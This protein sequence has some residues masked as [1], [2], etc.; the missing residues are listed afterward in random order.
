MG[1][2]TKSSFWTVMSQGLIFFIGL[3][4]SIIVARMLNPEGKGIYVLAVL[5]PALLPYFAHFGIGLAAVFYLGNGKYSPKL[6]LGNNVILAFLHSVFAILIGLMVIYFAGKRLF[7]GVDKR[8]LLI[9]L[10][11][12][13]SQLC[14]GLVL[15]ILLGL[16]KIALYN[17]IQILRAI[18]LFGLVLFFLVG[19]DSGVMGAI[20]TEIIA[21]L[22]VCFAT[23]F[24]VLRHTNGILLKLDRHYLKDAYSYGIILYFSYIFSILSTRLNLLLINMYLNPYMVGLFT[25]G[26]GISEKVWLVAD[27]V[28]T[29]LYQKVA[30][31]PDAERRRMFTPLVFKAILLIVIV[32]CLVLYIFGEYL[33]VFLYSNAFREAVKPFR[34]LLVGVIGSSGWRMLQ[35]DLMGRGKPAFVT[36][37]AGFSF[38]VNILLCLLLIPKNLLPGA[39][40]AGAISGII[41]L[42]VGVFIYRKISGNKMVELFFPQRSDLRTYRDVIFSL[43]PNR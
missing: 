31:E 33:I 13:P 20:V 27:A 21:S 37:V 16:G 39:A 2:F 1:T 6:V 23:L 4:T 26:V 29:V 10:L 28:S 14:L 18:L 7:P 34:I 40:W 30:S 19:L 12:V 11:I 35:S 42:L 36:F 5:L 17:L 8:Y 25:V 38:I 32:I 9:S 41:T 22:V 24:I 15:P 43:M 3:G